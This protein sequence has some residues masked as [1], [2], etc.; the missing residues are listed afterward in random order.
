[1]KTSFKILSTFIFLLFLS[2]TASA[3]KKIQTDTLSVTGVCEMCQKRIENAAFIRG[4]KS[5]SWSVDNQ[6]LTVIYKTKKTDMDEIS[7]AVAEAG[8][9]NTR[10]KATDEAYDELP[11][12]CAYRDGVKAH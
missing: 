3:Q 10:K 12:C 5:A 6:L 11:D 1:M 2:F 9:D 8:H 4:V 7:A